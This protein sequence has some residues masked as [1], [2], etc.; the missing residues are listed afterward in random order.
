MFEKIMDWTISNQAPKTLYSY[1]EGS[2]TI[3]MGVGLQ[4]I[5]KSKWWV[6]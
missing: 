5:G 4:A 2:T 6:L 3:P 1:G